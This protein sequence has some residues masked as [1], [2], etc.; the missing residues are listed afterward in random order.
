M[1]LQKGLYN[2]LLRSLRSSVFADAALHGMWARPLTLVRGCQD[3][4]FRLFDR[5]FALAASAI[6]EVQVTQRLFI[7]A[8]ND[9]RGE[10]AGISVPIGEKGQRD[11]SHS[12]RALSASNL[13]NICC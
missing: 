8:A 11:H 1:T 5:L 13:R 3:V 12:P 6:A 7:S 4:V 10:E 2:L 9:E